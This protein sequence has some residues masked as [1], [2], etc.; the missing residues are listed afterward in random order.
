M[1]HYVYI[2]RS[3][4]TGRLYV[5]TTDDVT[6][7]VDEHNRGA[8]RGTKPWRPWQLVYA[9]RHSDAGAARRREWRLKCTPAGGKE[10]RRLA[11]H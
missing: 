6:R 2:L 5:G 4:R 10:K 7:R 9:E 11:G 1:A 3:L 8:S